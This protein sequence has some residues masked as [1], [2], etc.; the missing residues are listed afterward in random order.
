MPTVLQKTKKKRN[1]CEKYFFF[2]R[3][4]KSM[5]VLLAAKFLSFNPF[6]CILLIDKWIKNHLNPF[7]FAIFTTWKAKSAQSLWIKREIAQ[8]NID[9]LAD[10]HQTNTNTQ[11]T[12]TNRD[13]AFYSS[14]SN[15]GFINTHINCIC[16]HT[17][18]KIQIN[19]SWK[20]MMIFIPGDFV[21]VVVALLHFI[22]LVCIFFQTS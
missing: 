6:I 13:I 3:M 10:R 20:M 5:C 12:Y 14:K 18:N 7:F 16:T 8:W 15:I 1:C 19:C 9:L 2:L 11:Q 21:D 22:Y 4:K 17:V